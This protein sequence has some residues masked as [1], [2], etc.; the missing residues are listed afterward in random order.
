[1][2]AGF[3]ELG[4]GGAVRIVA[5]RADLAFHR[6]IAM[7]LFERTAILVVAFQAKGRFGLG[8]EE[9]LI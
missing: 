5:G 4:L 6:V 3:E 1:M 2:D 7:G 8:Q 9:L